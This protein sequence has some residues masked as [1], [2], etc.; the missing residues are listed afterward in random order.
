MTTVSM[1]TLLLA[2]LL[3]ISNSYASVPMLV[4]LHSTQLSGALPEPYRTFNLYIKLDKKT[5]NVKSFIIYRGKERIEIPDTYLAQLTDIELGT[6]RVSHEMHRA[7][8]KPAE[9]EFGDDGDWLTFNMESGE[10]YR[11]EKTI[12]GRDM[13][14]WGVDQIE[15]S[16]TKGGYIHVRRIKVAD[17]HDGWSIKTW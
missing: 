1:K 14:M 13:F 3:F 16:I 10:S 8:G 2:V 17:F 6:L 7:D 4:H 5:D 12:N 9:S 15:M 11:A